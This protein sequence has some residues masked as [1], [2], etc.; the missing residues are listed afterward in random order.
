M[1][2]K[3]LRLLLILLLGVLLIAG[4]NAC[5]NGL[6]ESDDEDDSDS[7]RLHDLSITN[8]KENTLTYYDEILRS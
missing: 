7:S 4:I 1:K 2:T 5:E 8:I 6:L 3:T